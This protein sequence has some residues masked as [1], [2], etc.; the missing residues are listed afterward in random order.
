MSHQPVVLYVEDDAKSRK[1]MSLLLKGRLGL[2]HVT[3]LE[4][5][6]DFMSQVAA[7]DPQPDVIFL[8]IHMKPYDGFEML[9]MLRNC[10]EFNQTP[11]VALTASVMNE[12]VQ[13]LQTSGFDGCLAKPIDLNTFPETFNRILN[14]EAVWRIFD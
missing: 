8:D 4:D 2:Q 9:Q 11:I 7:L 10:A 12:E 3:I 5:S 13:R 6:T 14:G 1:V